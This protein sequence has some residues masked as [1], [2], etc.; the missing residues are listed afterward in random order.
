MFRRN[1]H[2]QGAYTNVIKHTAI[3]QFY[4]NHTHQICTFDMYQMCIFDVYDNFIA[5]LFKTLV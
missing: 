1:C 3:N 5:V 2:L 4:N